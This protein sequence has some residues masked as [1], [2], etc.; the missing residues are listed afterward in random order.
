LQ[1]ELG[2][3]G[4]LGTKTTFLLP[5]IQPKL[6]ALCVELFEG[7]GFIIIRGLNSQEYSVEDS[8]IA[9]LGIQSYI[10]ELRG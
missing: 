6:E 8:T 5:N 2:L 7:R 9:F 10:A 3:D 4:D 1:P